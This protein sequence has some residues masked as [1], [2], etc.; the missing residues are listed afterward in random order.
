MIENV[1]LTAKQVAILFILI[2]VGWLCGKRRIIKREAVNSLIDLILY[3]VA[4]CVIITSFQREFNR[5]LLDGLIKT[6]VAALVSHLINIALARLL[7]HDKRR[8]REYVMRFAAVF[9]NCGY[10]SLPLQNAVLGSEGTFYGAAYIAVFNIFV[11]TYGVYL[12]SG[13]KNS[14]RVTTLLKTP[15]I[16]GVVIG[17][18][19]FVCSV[20]L[21]DIIT[22]PMRH[23]ANL[24]T[25]LPM[26]IIGYNLS[27]ASFKESGLL[28]S[29]GA[30]MCILC[31]LVI[32]PVIFAAVMYICGIRGAVLTACAIAAAAPSAANTNM[33]AVKFS[34]D[35]SVSAQIVSVTTLLSALTMPLI[36]GAV[37]AFA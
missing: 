17:G 5:E 27:N 23:L 32:A 8:E 20:T 29:T 30:V 9:S 13:D 26:M 3:I 34:R 37:R 31:R 15:A 18:I 12:M 14:V 36:V 25:P 21:P 19:L 16:I 2:A 28:R 7:I 24:N 6:F 35:A 11:W 10:M 22:E 33:F 4:P 1:L